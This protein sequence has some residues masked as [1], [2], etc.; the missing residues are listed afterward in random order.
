[1]VY[2]FDTSAFSDIFNYYRPDTFP[3]LWE[4][5]NQYI[6]KGIIT[7][8]EEA[9]RELKNCDEWPEDINAWIQKNKAIFTPP[10]ESEQ[11][12]V[13]ELLKSSDGKGLV[14]QQ[15]IN[16][17]KPQADPWVIAKAH[18]LGAPVVSMEKRKNETNRRFPRGHSQIPDVCDRLEISCI[19]LL[20]FMSNEK[21]RF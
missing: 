6:A 17:G 8:V 4:K 18:V 3:T 19:K 13:Q 12:F 9:K 11:E 10:S 2:V 16:D 15:H 20:D 21:W 14:K 7:S 1:M 5:L